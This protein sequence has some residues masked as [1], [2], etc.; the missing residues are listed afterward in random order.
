[1]FL[2]VNQPLILYLMDNGHKNYSFS[3][4]KYYLLFVEQQMDTGE[5]AA[6]VGRGHELFLLL[7]PALLVRHVPVELPQFARVFQSV[8]PLSR[9]SNKLFISIL[10]GL[11]A[12][13]HNFRI[14]WV[15]AFKTVI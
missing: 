5:I 4:L 12:V 13:T 8:P 3:L 10:Q 6:Q 11:H 14:C 7:D 15:V 2:H 1:M 9:Q